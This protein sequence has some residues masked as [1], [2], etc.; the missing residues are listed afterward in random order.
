MY[1]IPMYQYEY[2]TAYFN[3]SYKSQR[4]IIFTDTLP[5]RTSHEVCSMQY[6]AE[7]QHESLLLKGGTFKVCSGWLRIGLIKIQIIF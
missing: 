3:R 1:S 5:Y 2:D 7:R 4:N 6:A